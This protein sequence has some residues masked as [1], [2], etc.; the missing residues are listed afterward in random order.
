MKVGDIVKV[1]AKSM[2][3]HGPVP[4]GILIRRTYTT[5][6]NKFNKWD[7]LVAGNIINLPEKYFGYC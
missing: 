6:E 1:Y 7:V 2:H 4:I 5:Y 3:K